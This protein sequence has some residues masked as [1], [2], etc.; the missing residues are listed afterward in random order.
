M[1]NLHDNLDLIQSLTADLGS[2]IEGLGLFLLPYECHMTV[3]I[4]V[5][6]VDIAETNFPNIYGSLYL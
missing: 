5:I 1:F 2:E 3:I 6:T 4:M